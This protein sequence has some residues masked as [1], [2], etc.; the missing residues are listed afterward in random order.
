MAIKQG[1][2]SEIFEISEICTERMCK[3]QLLKVF[4]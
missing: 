3:I 2:I 4:P 1:Q